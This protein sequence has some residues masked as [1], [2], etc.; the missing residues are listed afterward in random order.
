MTPV[1]F[2]LAWYS[3]AS[4]IF[5]QSHGIVYEPLN[6]LTVYT[7]VASTRVNIIIPSPRKLIKDSQGSLDCGKQKIEMPED[8]KVF[9]RVERTPVDCDHIY[10]LYDRTIYKVLDLK[11]VPEQQKRER[12]GAL[13]AAA[14][15]TVVIGVTGLFGY[16]LG[17]ASLSADRKAQED[18]DRREISRIQR[19]IELNAHNL[20]EVAALIQTSTDPA[21]MYAP[22]E[23]PES[24]QMAIRYAMATNAGF[25]DF[26]SDFTEDMG[27]KMI[28]NMLALSNNRLPT[29]L[30]FINSMRTY[31]LSQQTKST[32]E[33]LEH[34]RQFA[35]HCTRYDTS[36]RFAGVG[37]T[38]TDEHSSK[39]LI[40]DLVFSIT[41]EIPIYE[42]QGDLFETHNLGY[43]TS[44]QSRFLLPVPKHVARLPNNE[45]REIEPAHCLRFN[46]GH[47]CQVDKLVP[48]MC[49]LASFCSQNGT[50]C[51]PEKADPSKC[52]VWQ[53][54]TQR[55]VAVSLPKPSLLDFSNKRPAINLPAIA[56]INKT[57]DAAT[58]HCQARTIHIRPI[59]TT[60]VVNTTIRYLK[61]RLITE[62]VALEV[63]VNNLERYSQTLF[64][65][66]LE[67]DKR[68]A[69]ASEVLLNL[70]ENVTSSFTSIEERF[71]KWLHGIIS[72][73]SAVALVI[74]TIAI[75][76]CVVYRRLSSRIR[77]PPVVFGLQARSD[78]V[79]Q[80]SS[81]A[82]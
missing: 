70:K 7:E 42:F 6:K 28:H 48:N 79:V 82:V 13:V 19:A 2:L 61:P 31:C 71:Q 27:N 72:S 8:E 47:A 56:L 14:I 68:I 35:L 77:A 69:S 36:L 57:T 55:Q 50:G 65:R 49:V 73:I 17:E 38:L 52:G 25:A 39:Q 10:G 75:L 26:L 33:T 5:D 30:H 4:T 76:V 23:A 74:V 1:W 45:T 15:S 63:M 37:I 16:A 41:V 44:P 51:L 46:N 9:L 53:P 22:I 60:Q 78:A 59:R 34:C 40:E 67:T 43:F 64:N 58:L 18:F 66:T 3:N 81:A 20:A 32:P 12:R 29:D 54:A 24:A 62:D 21:A 80:H 11:I